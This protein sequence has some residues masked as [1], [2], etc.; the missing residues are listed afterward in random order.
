[1]AGKANEEVVK[2]PIPPANKKE[3][4]RV[5]YIG[6]NLSNGRLAQYTVFKDGV[7]K[8]LED[9][10][11]KNPVIKDLFVPLARLADAQA[12]IATVGTIEHQAYQLILKGVE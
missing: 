5:I 12:K 9:V 8:H 11:E 1:M 3:S 2:K 4:T 7:P 10:I 6:P